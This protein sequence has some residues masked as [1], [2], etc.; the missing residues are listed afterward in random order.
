MLAVYQRLD[1]QNLSTWE[2]SWQPA[3]NSKAEKADLE[4][5]QSKLTGKTVGELGV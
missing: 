3:C 5:A 2:V 4:D 1:P